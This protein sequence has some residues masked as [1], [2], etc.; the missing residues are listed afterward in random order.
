MTNPYLEPARVRAAL[1]SLDLRPTRAMGQNFLLDAA[2]L[3]A[4]VGAAELVPADTVVEVGPGLGVLTWEL[5]RRAGR[6]VS[7]ELD[8]RLAERLRAEFAGEPGFTLVQGDI[9]RQSPEQLLQNSQEPKNESQPSPGGSQ[10]P[11]PGPRYKVVA[12]LPYAITSAALRHFLEAAPPPAL[13]VVLV[14]WEVAERIAAAPGDMSVLAHSVQLYA[15]PEVIARVPAASFFPA[16]AV[17]SAILRLR[18]RP[19]PA[20]DVPPAALMRLIKAGFLQAR[21]KLANALPTG[22]AAIGTPLDKPRA[23]AALA[24][25]GIDPDRRA[26]TLSLAEWARLYSQLEGAGSEEPGARL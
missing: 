8:A 25:A 10:F 20:A 3:G 17:D 11:A 7:V 14:Q 12:N 2:V 18:I 24:A 19:Q 4:I 22:L 1:R 6:V 13:M 16:P 5:V 9:L 23:L 26:E 21:K 15:A